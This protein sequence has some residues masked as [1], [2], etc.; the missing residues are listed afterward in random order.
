MPANSAVSRRGF[1]GGVAGAI[2]FMGL[3][4]IDLRALGLRAPFRAAGQRQADQYDSLAKLANNEN[5]WGPSET[6][7]EAMNR[8]F[9]YANRYG[10]PDG[11]IVDAI[12]E[13]HGIE[14]DRILMG[15]G[16]GE[17]LDVVGST[18]LDGGK[19]VVGAEPSYGSVYSHA[20]SIKSEAILV[21]LLDDHR[22]DI[23]ALIDATRKNYREVG[24]VYLCNPNN[25]TGRTVSARE[26][27]Q[28]LD[29]IPEDVPVLIDE[30]YHHFI[31]DPSY[32]AS[33]PYVLEGRNV[34]IARTFS[35]IYGM[36]GMRLGYAIAKPEILRRM[37]PYSTGT[38][39]AIV[40]WGG[41]AALKDKDEEA[42]VRR[43]TIA[44]RKKAVA[45]I[46][47]MGYSVIPSE[48]NF[49]MVHIRRPVQ[50]VI[51]A[52][53]EKGVLVGR[54]FPPML[55]HLRV[56]VGLP[57]EMSR[58]FTAYRQIFDSAASEPGNRR[59]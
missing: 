2:G 58:F 31:E 39:N 42:R 9:K 11:G 51:A 22:Q 18:F 28:L 10:Y 20:T 49:F 8:A 21:D 17:I 24:F 32:E 55:D 5:P 45:D 12:A 41:V 35:K 34:I 50:P 14:R 4:P 54:P 23:P 48:T 38:I 33:I 27:R 44:I 47:A 3:T 13:H 37:R 57:E 43:E 19:K 30:A 7:L 56:S 15:A 1:V 29:G 6:V 52:F 16:S 26:V 36:A 59:G 46:E 25:P 53:R 40:K